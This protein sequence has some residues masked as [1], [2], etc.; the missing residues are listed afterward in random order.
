MTPIQHRGKPKGGNSQMSK[1]KIIFTNW[2]AYELRKKGF[3]IIRTEI[4]PNHP[5]LDCY[6]FNVSNIEVPF[7]DANDIFA[8]HNVYNG[9]ALL[10]IKANSFDFRVSRKLLT[11]GT[12]SALK[13]YLANY[14][15][16]ICGYVE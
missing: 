5:N 14:P 16:T 3:K 1:E 12:V 9:H 7:L 8:I 10:N 11:S 13:E 2:V 4:N 6:V 15:I